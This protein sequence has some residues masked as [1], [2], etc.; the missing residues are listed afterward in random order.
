MSLIPAG[1]VQ[2][3]GQQRHCRL[4]QQALAGLPVGGNNAQVYSE[5]GMAELH[6]ASYWW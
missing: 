6:E 2:Q 5:A 1:S 3:S 4:W